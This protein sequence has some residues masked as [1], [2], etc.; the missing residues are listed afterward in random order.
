M[1]DSLT[2]MCVNYNLDRD[3]LPTS[4]KKPIAEP[5]QTA[6]AL[7]DFML[8]REETGDFNLNCVIEHLGTC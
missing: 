5:N 8:L 2:I 4:L 3:N 1:S 6:A 7:R